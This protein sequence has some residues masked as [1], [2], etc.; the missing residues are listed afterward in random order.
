MGGIDAAALSE[1]ARALGIGLFISLGGSGIPSP[2]TQRRVC[3]YASLM[4]HDPGISRRLVNKGS[5]D[6]RVRSWDD[7]LDPERAI[8][9]GED[10]I[11]CVGVGV[12]AGHVY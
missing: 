4:I 9:Y 6:R 11:S 10:S 5:H 2:W 7:N 1:F 3:L 8:H 12:G